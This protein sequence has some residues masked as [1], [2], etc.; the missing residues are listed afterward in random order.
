MNQYNAKEPLL[1][2]TCGTAMEHMGGVTPGHSQT[3]RKGQIVVCMVCAS[4]SMVSDSGLSAIGK[5]Q[6]EKLDPRTQSALTTTINGVRGLQGM[7][8]P[9][10]N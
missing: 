7:G 9:S 6:F 1:C 4:P 2:P 5:E 3:I 10:E 8:G